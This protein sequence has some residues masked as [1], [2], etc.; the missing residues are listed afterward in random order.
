[1]RIVFILKLILFSL[2]LL[3]GQETDHCDIYATLLD[4]LN[5]NEEI[6]TSVGFNHEI[7][8]SLKL[9]LMESDLIKDENK[10]LFVKAAKSI[11]APL[12]NTVNDRLIR[13]RVV[14]NTDNLGSYE[15]YSYSDVFIGANGRHYVFMEKLNIKKNR[16]VYG[17]GTVL[18]LLSKQNKDWVIENTILLETY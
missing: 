8:N 15:K 18:Y 12:C 11:E 9:Y 3:N 4:Q 14:K 16:G 1:M 10:D 6:S 17:G 13:L 7:S 5:F 2:G